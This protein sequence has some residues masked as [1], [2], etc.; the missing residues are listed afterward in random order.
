MINISAI[1]NLLPQTQCGEC[2]YHGC[3]P[4]AA[5]IAKGEAAINL[6]PPGGAETLKALGALLNIDITPL[7]K[8]VRKPTIAIIREAECI[9]C[10]KCIAAC[11]VDA[12]IGSGK[13]LHT[14]LAN[15]CTGCNLCIEPCPVDCIE[16]RPVAALG[17]DKEL[18]KQ[19][20]Q[21]KNARQSDNLVIKN[22]TTQKK[23]FADNDQQAK[24]D[25]IIGAL[26]RVLSKKK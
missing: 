5:A 20:F 26:E 2:G 7:A 15:E 16:L 11:P 22:R 23:N 4:Y 3:L 14:V 12:I 17:F 1:D 21:A 13:L 25:Y 6:C 9:G 18:A 19:R 8:T 10:T 24:K